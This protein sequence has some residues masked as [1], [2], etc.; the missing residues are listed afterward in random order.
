MNNYVIFT[1]SCCDVSPEILAQWDVTYADMTFTFVGE[2]KEYI[3]TDISNKEFYDRM[4]RGAV[5]KTAAI[6]AAAFADAFEPILKEGKDILYI[7]FSSGFSTTVNSAYMAVADL[8]EQY[9]DR[10]IIVVDTLAASAGGGL[11][12]YMAV[13]KKRSGASLEEN[14]Q[15]I[16]SLVPS[17]A[18]GSPLMIWSI[19]K[20]VVE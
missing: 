7:A 4:K 1:D 13:N 6:N 12:V 2:D 3:S 18:F 15:Y 11:M 19:L 14:A 17:T 20:E 10:K 5:A 8:K 16:E 9:P